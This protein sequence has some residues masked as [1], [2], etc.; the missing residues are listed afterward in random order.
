MKRLVTWLRVGERSSSAFYFVVVLAIMLPLLRPGYL[1][2]LDLSWTPNIPVQGI[3]NDYYL[4]FLIL[5]F[6]NFILPSQLIEKAFLFGTLWLAASGMHRLVRD[7][8]ASDNWACYFAGLLYLFSPFAYSRFL[9]GQYLILLAFA[10]MPWFVSS[11]WHFLTSPNL[12]S[13]FQLLLWALAV[14]IVDL[15]SIFFM[16]LIIALSLIGIPLTT[17]V[18]LRGQ[19]KW[20]LSAFLAWILLSSYWLLPLLFGSSSTAALIGHVNPE[21]AHAFQT[22]GDP[23]H[24]VLFNAAAMYGFWVDKIGRYIL[25]K[26]LVGF[27]PILATFFIV[28]A[29]VGLTAA[30]RNAFA[31]ILFATGLIAFVLGVGIAYPP[32]AGIYWFLFD[33]VPFFKG[34]REPE[35]FIGLLVMTYSFL[36][37]VGA[38]WLSNFV[39]RNFTRYHGELLGGTVL[40]FLIFIT[41]LVYNPVELWGFAGQMKTTNYPSDWYAVNRQLNQDKSNFQVLFLP[42]HMYL[43]FT[44]SNGVMANP[45]T[46]FFDKPTIQGDNIQIANIYSGVHTPTSLFVENNILATGPSSTHIGV[47]LDHLNIKYVI[48]AKNSDASQYQWLNRQR[49]VTMIDDTKDLIVYRNDAWRPAS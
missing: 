21:F 22:V 28:L 38:T 44:F 42:W 25:P 20:G 10:L 1:L 48:V 34:D 31:W 15:H 39:R 26:S 49:D 43:R 32:F 24:G 45:A 8:S 16:A 41:P 23:I 37:A 14:S 27:W 13:S 19:M 18:D 35:K 33:H 46:S 2:A 4:V 17:R 29:L 7:W 47:N 12:R 36:G 30:R 9:A 5:H 6:L 3:A 40:P 11:L